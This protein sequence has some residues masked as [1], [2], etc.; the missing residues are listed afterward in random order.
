[1]SSPTRHPEDLKRSRHNSM[2][3][4]TSAPPAKRI[5]SEL[6]IKSGL[7]LVP[8]RLRAERHKELDEVVLKQADTDLA[9]G[10]FSLISLGESVVVNSDGELD[11]FWTSTHL[12]EEMRNNRALIDELQAAWKNREF[13]QIRLLKL[14]NK[15][16]TTVIPRSDLS[17]QAT[18]EAWQ[19]K[20][21]GDHHELFLRAIDAMTNP[22]RVRGKIYWNYLPIVQSSGMGKSRLVD[23]VSTLIFTIP[24]NLRTTK[25]YPGADESVRNALLMSKA[26]AE[27]TEG[28]ASLARSSEHKQ[29]DSA[30]SDLQARYAAILAGVVGV[31]HKEVEKLTKSGTLSVR[32]DN[33]GQDFASKWR[34][35][36]LRVRSEL[37]VRGVTEGL[38]LLVT[39]PSPETDKLSDAAKMKDAFSRACQ[40]L[41][42]VVPHR[43]HQPW[44]LFSFDEAHELSDM[45]S[46][47]EDLK[48]P[49]RDV[50]RTPLDALLNVLD[51]V[52]DDHVFAVFL[53]TNSGLHKISRP[54]D[55]A[56]S[57]REIDEPNA[58][59]SN[60]ARQA[61]YVELPF[62][63]WNGKAIFSHGKDTLKSV[64][65]PEYICRFGRP[66]WWTRVQDNLGMLNDIFL[67]A[68]TKLLSMSAAD[69]KPLKPKGYTALAILS[70]R[71]ILEIEPRREANRML[72]DKLVA[73]H[74]RVAY[75]GPSHLQYLRSSY[76][77]EPPLVEAAAI[78]W[79]TSGF[80][81]LSHLE[82]YLED[83]LI[84]KGD[85]GE[86]VCQFLFI[87]AYDECIHDESVRKIGSE[88]ARYHQFVPVVDLLRK[89]FSAEVAE[90]ILSAPP[91][92]DPNGPKL[93]AAFSEAWIR[94]SHFARAGD[95][96]IL[97]PNLAGAII[98]R[99]AAWQ[100]RDAQQDI[101][102]LLECVHGDKDTPIE[103]MAVSRIAIQI[104]NTLREQ[105]VSVSSN[106]LYGSPN[107]PF[108]ERPHMIIVLDLGAQGAHSIAAPPAQA[109]VLS[110]GGAP[111][112]S[113]ITA[114][115][116]SPSM[117]VKRDPVIPACQTHSGLQSTSPR[118]W[119][120]VVGCSP[121]IFNICIVPNKDR[122]KA[123]LASQPLLAEHVRQERP[124][125]EKLLELKPYFVEGARG[126]CF[127][128][129]EMEKPL[130]AEDQ[131]EG[132]DELQD[133]VEALVERDEVFD[134]D[135]KTSSLEN[136]FDSN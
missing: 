106:V 134:G 92:N 38:E 6:D 102:F 82:N 96:S 103:K 107:V 28:F 116:L 44:I 51:Y 30:M 32:N 62:D 68:Q 128:W 23:Q 42:K 12:M 33:S 63:T 124:Y 7:E 21:V 11:P 61:P 130:A 109:S 79:N 14:L 27:Q 10:I 36:L 123:L 89:L 87:R 67:F 54:R 64:C 29:V 60:S 90:K 114:M 105:A 50:V 73:S 56:A 59:S 49:S 13:R 77:S 129:R 81:A 91:S 39:P 101:D 66:L 71:L 18:A 85:R 70:N 86:V 112:D 83:G 113:Q 16:R 31:I 35:H 8:D 25:G 3:S 132:G 93:E 97:E 72:E 125:I 122:F 2:S 34:K 119:I 98:A 84:R 1:M 26:S 57:L 22:E 127:T 37:Y 75:S 115:F 4:S 52:K 135:E 100:C 20:Y 41:C 58:S 88:K 111:G 117:K 94:I 99:G 15:N 48:D 40:D 118:Y 80:D 47:S 9:N 17:D 19:V 46:L 131:H 110:P 126:P 121:Q 78:L 45:G 95:S 69:W 65:E 43:E 53:S 120:S 55:L 108:N 76:P 104:K 74:M 5:N 24:I 133:W 136:D